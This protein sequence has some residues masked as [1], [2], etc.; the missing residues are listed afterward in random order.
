MKTSKTS[1]FN[2][3]NIDDPENWARDVD[4][5]LSQIFLCL[6]GRVRFGANDTFTGKG[7]NIL[8]QFITY[9]SNGTPDTEDSIIHNL[10]SIPVGYI[11]VSK[12]KAGDVYQKANT[13]TAWTNNF[14]YLKCSVA[15]VS[16][17]LFLL[18]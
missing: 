3:Y 5:D 7:E 10:D 11:V 6:S 18:Q 12:D 1:N 2:L 8:G 17:T 4:A 15:S 9:T 13:G 16:V 14:I